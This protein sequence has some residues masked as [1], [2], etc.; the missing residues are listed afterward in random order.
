MIVTWDQR[1]MI[2]MLKKLFYYV[3]LKKFIIVFYL[4]FIQN[5][6]S[7][8]IIVMKPLNF[9]AFYFIIILKMGIVVKS[10]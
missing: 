8:K 3:V 5:S 4:L 9:L 7:L 2:C 10:R 1:P 6:D